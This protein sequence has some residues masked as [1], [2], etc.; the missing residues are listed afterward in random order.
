MCIRDRVKALQQALKSTQTAAEA[1]EAGFEAGTRTSVDVLLALSQTY[2]AQRDYSR[3]RYDFILNSL[4][5][6]QAAG[7]VTE[8]DINMINE[9]LISSS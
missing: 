5:L 8:T 4:R 9:W 1:A 2:A 6:K 7:A 3:A